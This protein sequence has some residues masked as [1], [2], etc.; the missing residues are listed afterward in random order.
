MSLLERCCVAASALFLVASSAKGIELPKD[1]EVWL[2]LR[3]EGF[4]IYS[5]ASVRETVDVARNLESMRRAV[6]HATNMN[7]RT[8]LTTKIYVFRDGATFTPFRDAM[9]EHREQMTGAFIA[10][11]DGNYIAINTERDSDGIVFH[12]LMHYFNNN[13]NPNLPLWLDEG[14]AEVYSTLR[15]NGEFVT[16][17]RPRRNHVRILRT[18]MNIRLKDLF[19]VDRRSSSYREGKGQN[20]FYAQ[21]WAL[22]HYL[23][24]GHI[25][26]KA[27]TPRF[28]ELLAQGRDPALAVK[29]AYGVSL[30][31]LE[32]ELRAYVRG[33]RFLTESYRISD[34]RPREVGMPVEMSRAGTLYHLGDLLAHTAVRNH[35]DAE[36]FL[37]AALEADPRH[38]G[39][40][41]TLGYL[42][43]L[44]GRKAEADA[45][46]RTAL[47]NAGDHF[48]PYLRAA[49]NIMRSMAET[50]PAERPAAARRA[51]ELFL[52][53]IERNP[54]IPRSH[55]GLGA[56]YL[57][58]GD[59]LDGI[60]SLEK[61]FAMAPSRT[62]FGYNLALLYARSGDF[63]R[64]RNLV[65]KLRERGTGEEYLLT[66]D[67]ALL[68][69]GLERINDLLR[70]GSAEE[71]RALASRLLVESGDGV[72]RSRLEQQLSA[73]DLSLEYKRSLA[74]YNRAVTLMNQQNIL[75]AR[76]VLDELIAAGGD[77]DLI[78]SA[79]GLRDRIAAAVDQ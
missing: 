1:D 39:A 66:A 54:E 79:V 6:T 5:N 55:G 71:A 67:E 18:R 34:L 73:I 62:S 36:R 70:R 74:L 78:A 25:D 29:E 65:A 31:H 63:A 32:A 38:S 27:H 17:G 52:Q 33:S 26:R 23:L 41:A 2:E 7:V 58:D 60:P 56:T 69:Q 43:A 22:T 59:P 10:H 9:F 68:N 15:L 46:Y 16:V 53:S 61:S 64:A 28:M 20:L 75:D 40:N 13:T 50:P 49:E 42:R 11:V 45:F 77:P 72:F 4:Q 57:S 35:R 51:R 8:P 24:F 30:D 76:K 12:E 3:I 21:S 37:F 19:A 48:L 44:H 14:L 47:E